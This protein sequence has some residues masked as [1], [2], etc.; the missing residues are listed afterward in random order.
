MLANILRCIILGSLSIALSSESV[1]ADGSEDR[2]PEVTRTLDL[3]YQ[4]QW[5]AERNGTR[6]TLFDVKGR[7]QEIPS[8]DRAAVLSS[9]ERIA[10]I[11]NDLLLNYGFAERGIERGMLDDPE[12]Q[13]EIFF[14]IMYMLARRER[15]ALQKENEL[16][17]YTTRAREYFLANPEEFNDLEEVTFT[18]IFLRSPVG[19]R[20]EALY[21]AGQLLESID[22][23]SE[24]DAIDLVQFEG[25]EVSVSRD[26][27][28][29]VTPERLE[30]RFAAG[31]K[32]MQPGDVAVI[33]S[34]FGV[35]VVRLDARKVG[36]AR[37][38]DEV[39]AQLE[40]RARQRHRQQVLRRSTEGFYAA[41][42]ILA[43]GAIQRIID[44]QD[45]ADD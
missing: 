28:E 1:F 27:V 19:Q 7:L 11:I 31:L 35:H 13:A 17:E 37:E 18:Q 25:D 43:D 42:L 33:E 21:R 12:V 26:S 2:D 10:Q 30:P 29:N 38:F 4:D 5:I 40:E 34:A 8:E 36:G 39:R 32:R 16:D 15:A 22:Q 14:R 9:P 3:D 20:A 45:S 41:P 6:I 23:P 44:S 24:L